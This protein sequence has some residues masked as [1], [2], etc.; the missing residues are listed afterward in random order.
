M[1]EMMAERGFYVVRF[2]NR[3][4]GLSSRLPTQPRLLFIRAALQS[5]CCGCCGCGIRLPYTLE[6]MA[7]DVAGLMTFLNIQS[8]H[9]MGS[10]MGGMIAQVFAMTYPSRTRSLCSVMSTTGNRKLPQPSVAVRRMM[11]SAYPKNA[12]PQQIID[13]KLRRS[14]MVA[15]PKYFDEADARQRIG[16]FEARC[17]DVS[18]AVRQLCAVLLAPDR[19]AALGQLTMPTLI[20]HGTS[21]PLVPYAHG[22]ATHKAIPNSE[23]YTIEE[24]G[25][26]LPR[27]FVAPIVDR[28]EQCC[29]RGTGGTPSASASIGYET[30]AL[31]SQRKPV[32]T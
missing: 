24:L 25:H 19:T 14:K 11:A 7:D 29:A 26:T 17:T 21:D 2:D 1:C 12:T 8:A 6:D 27:C 28:F 15:G 18:G 4:I 5:L 23:L 22:V 31:L 32:Y 3:D 20:C 30:G 9:I 13:E 10:S 16:E